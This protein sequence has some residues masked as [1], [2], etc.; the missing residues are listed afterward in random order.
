MMRQYDILKSA[1]S[2]LR[3]MVE[4]GVDERDVL[5]LDMYE[6]YRRLMK[7]GHK[8]MYIVRYLCE[9]YGIGEATIYRVANRMEKK[10]KI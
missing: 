10:L 2:L 4:N 1:V 9:Q 6:D 7:E 8:K 3:I 5:H